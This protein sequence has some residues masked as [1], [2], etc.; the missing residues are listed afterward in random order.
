MGVANLGGRPA[1]AL[2]S[3]PPG[4][5][6]AAS[7]LLLQMSS[8]SLGVWA[9]GPIA[10]CSGA[11]QPKTKLAPRLPPLSTTSSPSLSHYNLVPSSFPNSLPDL[12][13]SSIKPPPP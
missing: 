12:S 11:P 1:S 7:G 9:A 6:F 2:P 3:A 10:K 5:L 8:R 4:A 13:D